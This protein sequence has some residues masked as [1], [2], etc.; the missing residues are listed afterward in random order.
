M[1]SADASRQYDQCR[2]VDQQNEGAT[3]RTKGLQDQP[4]WN[5]GGHSLRYKWMLAP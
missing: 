3:L 1:C 2:Q 4:K 5:D